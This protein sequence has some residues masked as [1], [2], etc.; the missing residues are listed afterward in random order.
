MKSSSRE[1]IFCRESGPSFG[2]DD[3]MLCHNLKKGQTFANKLSNFISNNNLEL[4]GGKGN[5]ES[6]VTEEFE[7]YKVTFN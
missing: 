1:A 5:G 6:F 4:T 7:V 2:C 3:F